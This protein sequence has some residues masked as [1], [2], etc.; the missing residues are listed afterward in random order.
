MFTRGTR[1]WPIP[2]LLFFFNET[3]SSGHCTG[4]SET[5]PCNLTLEQLGRIWWEQPWLPDVAPKKWCTH[6]QW[7]VFHIY[8]IYVYVCIIYKT[9]LYIHTCI[10]HYIY[11]CIHIY[12]YTHGFLEGTGIYPDNGQNPFGIFWGSS[13]VLFDLQYP[14]G[15]SFGTSQV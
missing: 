9:T 12:I 13:Y 11:I 5:I 8:A 4:P 7:C 3:M 10:I 6:H 2:I 15:N 1:F 14:K